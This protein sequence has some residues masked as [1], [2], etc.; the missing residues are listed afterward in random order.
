[1]SRFI[2]V[3]FGP[4]PAGA[5]ANSCSHE[6]QVSLDD[7][8]VVL[9]ALPSAP[10]SDNAGPQRHNTHRGKPILSEIQ[11][12]EYRELTGRWHSELESAIAAGKTVFVPLTSPEVVYVR[13]DEHGS[14][15]ALRSTRPGVAEKSN[16][17]VLPFW[18]KRTITGVGREFRT[19]GRS[20][21]LGQYWTRFAALSHYEVRFAQQDR[22]EPL[23]T[24]KNPDHIVSAV[25]EYEGGGHLVFLPA[26]DLEVRSGSA[27]RAN[28]IDLVRHLL[29]VHAELSGGDPTPA[30]IGFRTPNSRQPISAGCARRC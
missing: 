5:G 24:T 21:V 20:Q 14:S 25:V 1:M 3:G 9:F 4:L 10:G 15:G 8:D 29:G 6:S 11:S 17:G 30:P 28:C 22:L 16:L 12:F 2:A 23:L 13:A 27:F 7:A 26:F 19:M 18:L